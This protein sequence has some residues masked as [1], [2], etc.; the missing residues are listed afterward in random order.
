MDAVMLGS[1]LKE[2][3]IQGD[4]T[5]EDAW[6]PWLRTQPLAQ[7]LFLA[8]MGEAQRLVVVAPHPDDEVLACGG[9]LAMQAQRGGQV[10]VIGVT[11]GERSHADIPGVNANALAVRRAAERLEGA[12]RLGFEPDNV[13]ALRLP[14]AALR[15]FEHRLVARLTGLLAKTDIV[16]STWRLDGHPDHDVS[17][18]AAA[19]ACASVGCR[20]VEAPVWMWHWANPA[21]PRVP[22]HRM[23]AVPLSDQ[24]LAAKRAALSAH[25]SQLRARSPDLGPVLDEQICA[26][27]E[28]PFEYFLT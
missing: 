13:T 23:T 14:D 11:D 12:R 3:L 10:L 4:G 17:G 5:P 20:H 9:L 22:W 24:A 25:T 28:Q 15:K 27:T 1:A 21:D 16:V 26:R 19:R 8:F 18:L 6:R 2:R 7:M